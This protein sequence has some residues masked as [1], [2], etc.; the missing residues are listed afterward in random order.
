MNTKKITNEEIQAGG[1]F[2]VTH[3]R[4]GEVLSV[5]ENHNIVVNEGLNLLL[6]RALGSAA[7]GPLYIGLFS[8]N[9]TPVATDTGATFPVSAT[10]YV[11]YSETSRQLFNVVISGTGAN[12]T[13][14][15]STFTIATGA[16]TYGCFIHSNS[17]KN[18][19]IGSMFS[20]N[21]FNSPKVLAAG[22]QITIEY[23]FGMASL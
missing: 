4:N 13:A 1:R 5:D 9:Y 14:S 6:S 3:I 7:Q 21:L 10:E 18:S 12:N 17:A 16:T 22:D 2:K 20:A 23:I 8:G 19:V 11:G 15:K